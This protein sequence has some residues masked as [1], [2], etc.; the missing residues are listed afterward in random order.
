MSFDEAI[1]LARLIRETPGWH[2]LGVE[3]RS[4]SKLDDEQWAGEA[5]HEA[6]W[7]YFHYWERPGTVAEWPAH[8]Q[9]WLTAQ[10][11]RHNRE[12]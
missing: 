3:V 1:Q 10:E 2:L 6:N 8:A 4:G 9:A 5:I 7:R 11:T 12:I